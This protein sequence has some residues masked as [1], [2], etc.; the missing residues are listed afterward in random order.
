MSL[1]VGGG[2][3][4]DPEEAPGIA[5][6]T[7]H[8]MM[9]GNSKS[10]RP[11]EFEDLLSTNYGSSNSFTDSEKTTF[12]YE[13]NFE[14][15]EQSL[16]LFS[17]MLTDPMINAETVKSQL[18]IIQKEIE[19]KVGDDQ[20]RENQVLKSLANSAHPYSK[21]S[22]GDLQKLRKLDDNYLANLVKIFYS[23]F[24]TPQN[25]K[26]VVSSHMNIEPMEKLVS[27]YFSDIRSETS[28]SPPPK[29][30]INDVKAFTRARPNSL[31][32]KIV[33]CLPYP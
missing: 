26:L 7:E 22:L 10:L 18:E 1:T 31:V 32:P 29:Q 14:G 16:K 15:M 17:R 24:Y 27:Q 21:F 13:L 20:W 8:V 30:V 11:M 5:H 25:M 23:K 19:G 4:A 12:Y 3:F 9:L 2:S 33:L 28:N 6:L